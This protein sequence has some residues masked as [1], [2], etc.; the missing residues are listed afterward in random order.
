LWREQANCFTASSHLCF[1]AILQ[2]LSGLNNIS[3]NNGYKIEK[4]VETTK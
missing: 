2:A 4:Q 1:P 3:W